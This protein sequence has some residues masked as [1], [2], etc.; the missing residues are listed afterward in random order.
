MYCGTCGTQ[1]ALCEEFVFYMNY[2]FAVQV[3]TAI[4][5]H[6]YVIQAVLIQVYENT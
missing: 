5:F 1:D 4:Y 2:Y 3:C 6:C